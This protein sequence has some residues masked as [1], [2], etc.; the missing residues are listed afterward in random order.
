MDWYWE[1]IPP[2]SSLPSPQTVTW[3]Q[4]AP[5]SHSLQCSPSPPPWMTSFLLTTSLRATTAY[6]EP[7]TSFKGLFIR[8]SLVILVTLQADV[9]MPSLPSIL[10][11]LENEI[12]TISLNFKLIFEGT[13]GLTVASARVNLELSAPF[14]HLNPTP[15]TTATSPP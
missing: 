2:C 11:A 7:G 9:K 5:V 12:F 6:I 13:K 3:V 8:E 14:V 10:N 1:G 4:W 15:Q